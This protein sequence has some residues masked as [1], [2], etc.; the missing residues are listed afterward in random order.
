MKGQG[1]KFGVGWHKTQ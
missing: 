1:Q